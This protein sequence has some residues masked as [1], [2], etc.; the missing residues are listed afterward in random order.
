MTGVVF[1]WKEI[2]ETLRTSKIYVL[3]V[4]FLFFGFTSPLFAKLM[5]EIIKFAGQGANF[6]II[7]EITPTA[8][9]SLQQFLKNSGTG[10]L[11]IILVFMGTVLDEKTRGTSILVLSKPLKRPAFIWAKFSSAALLTTF[12]ITLGTIACIYYNFVLWPNQPE[13]V[14]TLKLGLLILTF[15]LFLT[16]V[17]VLASTLATSSMLAAGGVILVYIIVSFLPLLGKAWAKYTPYGLITYAGKM[18]MPSGQ[19][20]FSETGVT[21]LVTVIVTLGLV[22][23]AG[24]L[25]ER[26]EL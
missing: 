19:V 1:F 2:K 3:P 12:A 25:F 5:P 23:L 6:R 4:I 11:A 13:T 15:G 7:M 16:A 18:I 14:L 24:L 26:Q 17:T 21:I 22:W 10:L 8:L 9:D 20:D